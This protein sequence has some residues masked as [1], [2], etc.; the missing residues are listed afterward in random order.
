MDEEIV[1]GTLKPGYGRC[2]SYP[3]DIKA[4][5]EIKT[6]ENGYVLDRE[7]GAVPD[8]RKL[9]RQGGCGIGKDG[10]SFEQVLDQLDMSA[11]KKQEAKLAAEKKRLEERL[12]KEEAEVNRLRGMSE[13]DLLVELVLLMKKATVKEEVVRVG[14]LKKKFD[15]DKWSVATDAF[16]DE[17]RILSGIK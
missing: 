9:P 2:G 10:Q 6:D 5:D 15:Y 4:L 17:Q 12:K 8:I 14:G 1:I 7:V 11:L 16:K 13:K 3:R